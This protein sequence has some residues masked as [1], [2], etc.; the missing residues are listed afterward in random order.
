MDNFFF[1][2]LMISLLLII[3]NETIY[4]IGE[5][6]MKTESYYTVIANTSIPV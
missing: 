3:N 5:Y 2:Q 1:D 6:D 4:V